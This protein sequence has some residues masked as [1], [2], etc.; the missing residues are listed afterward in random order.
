MAT[1][2]DA[3]VNLTRTRVDA[4]SL[5]LPRVL[6]GAQR[7]LF[8]CCCSRPLLNM[9]QRIVL[10]CCHDI[11]WLRKPTAN[12][13]QPIAA[14]PQRRTTATTTTRVESENRKRIARSGLRSV[15]SWLEVTIVSDKTKRKGRSSRRGNRRPLFGWVHS[16]W[17]SMRGER[18]LS[19]SVNS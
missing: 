10:T 14:N 1:A 9:I 4:L 17:E 5:P 6:A 16:R 13:L 11:F 2:R 15:F 7:H 12:D 8:V 19:G 18:S 3:M